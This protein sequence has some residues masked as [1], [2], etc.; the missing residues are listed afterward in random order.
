MPLPMIVLL[1]VRP[2]ERAQ[3]SREVHLRFGGYAAAWVASPKA[4]VS[5]SATRKIGLPPVG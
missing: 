3:A 2:E 1:L 5:S 4:I